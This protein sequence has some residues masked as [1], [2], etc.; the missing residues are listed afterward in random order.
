MDEAEAEP[1]LWGSCIVGTPRGSSPPVYFRLPK[2]AGMTVLWKNYSSSGISVK[3]GA[4]YIEDKEEEEDVLGSPCEMDGASANITVNDVSKEEGLQVWDKDELFSTAIFVPNCAFR[5]PD[6]G[7]VDLKTS[8]P[9]SRFGK[10][11]LYVE[12]KFAVGGANSQSLVVLKEHGVRRC[13]WRGVKISGYAAP[14][15]SDLVADAASNLRI[16]ALNFTRRAVSKYTT[17]EWIGRRNRPAVTVDWEQEG[18]SPVIAECKGS[19][20]RMPIPQQSNSCT[21]FSLTSFL[22]VYAL[23]Q[24]EW[25]TFPSDPF[26]ILYSTCLSDLQ[27]KIQ[28]KLSNLRALR[29]RESHFYSAA[30][31]FVQPPLPPGKLMQ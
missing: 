30:F 29:S 10:G 5:R 16:F 13:T 26:S 27:G 4:C 11:R 31:A 7:D 23:P 15:C 14:I 21:F 24:H 9:L 2:E 12:L 18:E 6:E 19:F 22:C 17:L 25:S 3:H 20:E 1:V 8:F 28:P